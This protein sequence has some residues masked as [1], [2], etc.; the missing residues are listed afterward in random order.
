MGLQDDLKRYREVGEENRQDLKDFIRTGEMQTGGGI[1]IPIKII[2]L[3]EFKYNKWDQGGIGQGEGAE[4]GDPVDAQPQEGEEDGDPGEDEGEHGYYDMDPEEFAEEL[5]KELNLNL[6]P[7]GKKVTD[8]IGGDLTDLARSGPNSTLDFERMFK[9]GLKRKLALDFDSE[10]LEKV[11]RVRGFGVEKA[12]R[13]AR[14]NNIPVSRAQVKDMYNSIPEA[15]KT[16]YSSI[17]DIPGEPEITPTVGDVDSIPLRQQDK[18]HKYPEITEEKQKNVV[19]VNIRDVSGSMREEKR[20]MVERVFTPLDWYL[21][22][23][24]DHAEF[25][26][27]AHDATA[28]EVEREDFFGIKSSGGTQI[29]SAYELAQSILTEEYPW[30][31]WNRYVFAAGDGENTTKNSKEEV[32]PLMED[33]SANLHGYVQVKPGGTGRGDH[34]NILEN[35][36]G[37]D[38]TEVAISRV[39]KMDSVVDSIQ[40]ILSTESDTQ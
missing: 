34:A 16:T 5:D 40:E 27:I 31:E 25:I 10:Y 12:W 22:G 37:E 33:I 15:Q 39:H 4:Q 21:T 20:E 28:W 17:E 30:D 36:F 24:Y 9:K 38:S 32:I 7:K 8:E 11:L 14:E 35:Y 2:S 1:K 29:S 6:Q 26:Y 19:V 3:P 13:W 23:K 18:R